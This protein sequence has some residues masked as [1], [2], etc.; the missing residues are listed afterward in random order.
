M[1][2]IHLVAA[3]VASVL[4]LCSS[5]PA[6]DLSHKGTANCYI[7]SAPGQY[8]FDARVK[9]GS[10]I[11]VG[12]AASAQVLWESFGTADAPAKGSIVSDVVLKDGFVFFSTAEKLAD[13]NALIAVYDASGNILWSW[14][15][16]VCE[17]FDPVRT[18]QVYANA[19]GTMMDR[20]LGATSATPGDVH[21]LGLLY[22]WGRKDPFLGSAYAI[23]A[24]LQKQETA[25]S[26]LEWPE[27]VK[28]SG[29]TGTVG[30]AVAHPTTFILRNNSTFDWLCDDSTEGEGLW[31]S[32][33]TENDPCPAGWRVPDGGPDGI[34][35]KAWGSSQYVRDGL[36]D[37]EYKGF[38][39][40]EA[41][42]KRK[43]GHQD[44]IWYP[45]AGFKS[46]N[47]GAIKF[48]GFDGYC[49]SCTPCRTDAYYLAYHYDAYVYPMGDY[50][51]AMG[52]SVRCVKE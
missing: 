30:Y 50:G 44:M 28:P 19:A 39:F 14:H 35:S 22:Q 2:T 31:G 11:S 37:S 29:E 43:F 34:W 10:G 5:K 49:W 38:N 6:L 32:V 42:G 21:C 4:L 47:D 26:T 51:K 12:K 46:L 25:A 7:V 23:N 16:W 17:G 52:L 45:T 13:G 20:N 40:G 3:A 41:A 33:K 18:A 8:C 9:G 24:S 36:L 15:I 1:K 48:A 27:A